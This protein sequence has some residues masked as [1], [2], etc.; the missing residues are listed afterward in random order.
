MVIDKISKLLED[1]K[2]NLNE[3]KELIEIFKRISYDESEEELLRLLGIVAGKAFIGPAY[4]HLDISNS[5]N[6]NCSYCWF[7]SETAQDREYSD[8]W[9][10]T[11][12]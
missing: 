12:N 4:F 5:C 8:R 10:K 6:M 2:F 11:A 9:K 7:H 3:K 1:S